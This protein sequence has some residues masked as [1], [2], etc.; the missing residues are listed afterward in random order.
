M[1][2]EIPE[3]Y[4]TTETSHAKDHVRDALEMELDDQGI[5]PYSERSDQPAPDLIDLADAVVERL[6]KEGVIIPETIRTLL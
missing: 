3:G 6:L 1:S 5:D 2:T 4:E